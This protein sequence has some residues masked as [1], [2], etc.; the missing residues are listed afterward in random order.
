MEDLE[1]LW[2]I[3]VYVEF[4]LEIW[5]TKGKFQVLKNLVGSIN[6]FV[7]NIVKGRNNGGF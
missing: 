4:V 3:L 1:V 7:S 2:V 5:L 6:K